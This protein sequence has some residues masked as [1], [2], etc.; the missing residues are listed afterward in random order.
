MK[1]F[2]IISCG[3][4]GGIALTRMPGRI[5]LIWSF[6]WLW[7]LWRRN[8]VCTFG[9]PV[10]R[11]G[12]T[13]LPGFPEPQSISKSN[14][15][16]RL[17]NPS[18]VSANPS[19]PHGPNQ[20]P[21]LAGPQSYQPTTARVRVANRPDNH[22]VKT[23]VPLEPSAKML[24]PAPAR[25]GRVLPPSPQPASGA[26]VVET[27]E[28][29]LPKSHAKTSITL[30]TKRPGATNLAF[31][32]S[33]LS[34]HCI[35]QSKR[36]PM[37]IMVQD[38]GQKRILRFIAPGSSS[39]AALAASGIALE[40]T[41]NSESA[42]YCK[43]RAGPP[44]HGT[45]AFMEFSSSAPVKNGLMEP[46]NIGDG[47][48]IQRG[49]VVG[50]GSG[51][52]Q[53]PPHPVRCRMRS[54]VVDTDNLVWTYAN[55]MRA[56]LATIVQI[57]TDMNK[58][59]A[60]DAH[61]SSTLPEMRLLM[62]GG[63]GGQLALS[64]FSHFPSIAVHV[65]EIDEEVALVGR[66]F[67]GLWTSSDERLLVFPGEEGRSF[68]HEARGYYQF[69]IIDAFN[70]ANG[71]VPNALLTC[72][73]L[74]EMRQAM[75]TNQLGGIPSIIMFNLVS[76]D[77]RTIKSALATYAHVFGDSSTFVRDI[78]ETGQF[79]VLVLIFGSDV[80]DKKDAS[81]AVL[82]DMYK[83]FSPVGVWFQHELGATGINKNDR[84]LLISDP[85]KQC[86]T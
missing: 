79:F 28:I 41:S 22:L 23:M 12:R 42:V 5:S 35:F 73:F 27:K 11:R 62:I 77:T 75:A 57:A 15:A 7:W 51:E 16:R 3:D 21:T 24:V 50:I 74:S 19:I 81:M 46:W 48:N 82:G 69:I 26:L 29:D 83:E 84:V 38:V 47:S 20:L 31:S 52:A 53:A 85:G 80:V 14:T 30:P 76:S 78:G 55:Q 25:A 66:T 67:F 43:D 45:T 58:G 34:D 4:A 70:N 54:C 10:R 65:V 18:A 13:R 32:S 40:L 49:G 6:V 37:R 59:A 2:V 44:S 61:E 33:L 60:T 8:I 39:E 64:I 71:E 56:T 1:F 9:A 86:L 17:G 68:I 36:G 63:G 72:Q